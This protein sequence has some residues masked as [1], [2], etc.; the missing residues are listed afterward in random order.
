M[1][2]LLLVFLS[3][4]LSLS[5]CWFQQPRIRTPPLF[6]KEFHGVNLL[7]KGSPRSFECHNTR[8]DSLIEPEVF[9]CGE[10]RLP[11]SPYFFSVEESHVWLLRWARNDLLLPR[12]SKEREERVFPYHNL[13]KFSEYRLSPES[14]RFDLITNIF[15]TYM[16]DLKQAKAFV[17]ANLDQISPAFFSQALVMAKFAARYKNNTEEITR[18]NKIFDRYRL[19]VDSLTFPLHIEVLKA[20]TRV[21][22]YVVRNEIN[23]SIKLWD[24]TEVDCYF[25]TLL[26]S[27]MKWA[28][29]VQEMDDYIEEKAANIPSL[30]RYEEKVRLRKSSLRNRLTAT[31]YQQA[32]DRFHEEFPFSY[33]TLSPELKFVA[34]SFAVPAEELQRYATDI[35]SKLPDNYFFRFASERFCSKF[36]VNL[37][38]LKQRLLVLSNFLDS[39]L[40]SYLDSDSFSII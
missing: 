32:T 22:T 18:L 38:E 36:G 23:R 24:R 15:S 5:K 3:T 1:K 13:R 40:V 4:L 28:A 31:V 29:T 25:L 16:E 34:E 10:P 39:F 11:P 12:N 17:L 26:A 8:G 30:F 21:A 33:E 35:C 14:L 6:T 19:T 7:R 2:I 27:R 20:E 9:L 37:V